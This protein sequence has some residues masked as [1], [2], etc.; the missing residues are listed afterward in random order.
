MKEFPWKKWIGRMN[1]DIFMS[2]AKILTTYTWWQHHPWQPSDIAMTRQRLREMEKE[3]TREWQ[4]NCAGRGAVNQQG[5]KQVAGKAS[6][7]LLSFEVI[8]VLLCVEERWGNKLFHECTCPGRAFQIAVYSGQETIIFKYSSLPRGTGIKWKAIHQAV[9]W[10]Y[11][12][13]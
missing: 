1:G 2:G 6:C 11:I 10:N 4:A 7:K 3:Q 12:E 8:E 13:S 5:E 9:K